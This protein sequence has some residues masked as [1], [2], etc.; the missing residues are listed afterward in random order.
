MILLLFRDKNCAV[1][2]YGFKEAIEKCYG[3]FGLQVQDRGYLHVPI[4][5]PKLNA[6]K[7]LKYLGHICGDNL[8]L[9]LLDCEIYY[10]GI[11]NLIGCSTDRSALLSTFGIEFDILIKE[12]FHEVGHIL[13]L[14]HCQGD[15]VM[16]L[17]IPTDKIKKKSSQ[18]CESCS[19]LLRTNRS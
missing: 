14:D 16:R 6:A 9:W 11:G 17:T 7:L 5:G 10:P 13:G 19:N 18:L 4:Q 1:Q 15:C 12:A 8:S 3:R 2:L